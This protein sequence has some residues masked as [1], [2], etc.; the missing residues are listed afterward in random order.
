[1]MGLPA[2]SM[3]GFQTGTGIVDRVLGAVEVSEVPGVGV[4]VEATLI[5]MMMIFSEAVVEVIDQT[6]VGLE[7]LEALRM[8]GQLEVEDQTGLHPGT[9]ICL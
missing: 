4:V 6:I 5:M 1:M 2:T 3:A 8:I 7:V 9:G